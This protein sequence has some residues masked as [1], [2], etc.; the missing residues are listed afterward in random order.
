ML[1]LLLSSSDAAH[2]QGL[3]TVPA[4]EAGD[5][6]VVVSMHFAFHELR[7]AAAVHDAAAPNG[8]REVRASIDYDVSGAVVEVAGSV[9]PCS[10][11]VVVE[12]VAP[13]VETPGTLLG[14]RELTS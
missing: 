3:D 5:R 6:T 12:E 14:S 8:V 1:Q 11:P 10:T 9:A 13:I 4:N 2:A 7:V